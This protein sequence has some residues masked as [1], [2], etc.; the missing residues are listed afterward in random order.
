MIFLSVCGIMRSGEV[1]MVAGDQS[2]MRLKG[3]QMRGWDEPD[4]ND[5]R[6]VIGSWKQSQQV[7]GPWDEGPCCWLGWSCG[8]FYYHRAQSRLKLFRRL[9]ARVLIFSC[10]VVG[11]VVWRQVGVGDL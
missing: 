4:R 1:E 10:F 3:T 8:H 9:D 5:A 7:K 11:V 6:V 2:A